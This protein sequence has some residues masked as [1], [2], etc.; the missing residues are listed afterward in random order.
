MNAKCIEK[1]LVISE[2][3]VKQSLTMRFLN[4]IYVLKQ[5]LLHFF[6]IIFTAG[7][8]IG[9]IIFTFI[10]LANSGNVKLRLILKNN[11]LSLDKDKLHALK[12]FDG[13]V[14]VPNLSVCGS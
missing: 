13:A 7:N 14:Y 4:G 12:I 1:I 11:D 9:R 5:L 6:R 2:N 10:S 3:I 8:I